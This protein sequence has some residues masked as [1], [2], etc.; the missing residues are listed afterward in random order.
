MTSRRAA[1]PELSAYRDGARSA[2]PWH[3]INWANV[4]IGAG[5]GGLIC[6][7][8]FIAMVGWAG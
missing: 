2:F 1:L 5:L 6:V 7:I 3:A 4:Y 8:V